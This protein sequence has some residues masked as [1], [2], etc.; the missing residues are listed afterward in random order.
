MM[1]KIALALTSIT[2]IQFG[3]AQTQATQAPQSYNLDAIYQLAAEN[4]ATY[5]AAQST[6]DA[7][8][9]TAPIAFGAL[10]PS[11]N[12][13]YSIGYTRNYGGSQNE[14]LNQNIG[15]TANQL[16]FNWSTWEV[17]SQAQYQTKADAIAFAQAQQDLILNTAQVYF[18]VL[19]AQENLDYANANEQWNK[20][21]LSQTEQKFQSGLATQTDVQ[22]IKAQYQTSV[23]QQVQAKSDLITAF[24]NL[25]KLTGKNI[26]AVDSLKDGFPFDNPTPN[27]V[28]DWIATAMKQ[29]LEI[30]R[31]QYIQQA[32][33]AG[34]GVTFGTFLPNASLSASIARLYDKNYNT[35]T[36][37]NGNRST[38]GATANWNLLNGGSD[39][40]SYKQS[41]FLNQAA[42]FGV[43][44]AQ[45]AVQAD[46]N[47]T[48]NQVVTDVSLV[49]AYHQAV[50]AAQASVDD[51]KAGYEV[52]TQTIVDLLQQQQILFQAQ[53]NYADAK[54]RYINDL[55]LL[56]KVAGNLI[57]D[58][59]QIINPWLSNTSLTDEPSAEQNQ[60]AITTPS[61]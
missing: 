28:N 33:D 49:Q 44:E 3:F 61:A 17:F 29:N 34:V 53:Q 11:V 27:D 46:I 40:A 51:M 41:K 4:N 25:E 13:G 36:N 52:G 26:A 8:R 39:Y 50:I 55:L 57:Y 35:S 56:K 47:I 20:E 12:A 54:F 38:I 59:I 6:F 58:D 21:L 9:Q 24:A 10:L 23:A 14:T 48:F 42:Q 31:S 5:L 22:T 32:A 1:K 2:F 19:Q 15:L 30:I 37:T 60:S 43:L 7:A 18:N 45:R 16:L